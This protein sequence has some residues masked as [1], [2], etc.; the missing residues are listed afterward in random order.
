[1]LQNSRSSAILDHN[2]N[3]IFSVGNANMVSLDFGSVT[4]TAAGSLAWE[5]VGTP[6]IAAEN[7]RVTAAGASNHISELSC[8]TLS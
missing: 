4:N 2:T 7:Y 5:V 3:V 6:K 8:W 1:M